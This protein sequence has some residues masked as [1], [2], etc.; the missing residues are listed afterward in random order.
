M[1]TFSNRT[2]GY[3]FSNIQNAS[4]IRMHYFYNRKSFF[5]HFQHRL[6]AFIKKK[7]IR[8]TYNDRK[9]ACII[10]FEMITFK[11][12]L[13]SAQNTRSK[14]K[15]FFSC[16]NSCLVA[17]NGERA[18]ERVWILQN[19]KTKFVKMKTWSICNKSFVCV[20][21]HAMI[22]NQI[23]NQARRTTIQKKKTTTTQKN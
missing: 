7:K 9:H 1:W 3:L 22:T 11:I 10:R 17:R 8:I 5:P 2:E 16:K 20:E 23:R 4:W 18:C 21:S 15:F 19:R 14:E 13:T 12:T 6:I